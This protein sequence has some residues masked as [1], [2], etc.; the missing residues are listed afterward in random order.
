MHFA[1]RPLAAAGLSV[2]AACGSITDPTSSSRFP[3]DASFAKG[4]GKP[5][6]SPRPPILFVHGWNSNGSIWNTMIGRFQR[7]GWTSAQLHTFSYNSALSNTTTAAILDQKVDSIRTATGAAKVAI[8]THSMGSLSARYY[9]LNLGGD[10]LVSALVS[11]G[12][13][14]HGTSTAAACALFFGQP[15]CVEMMPNSTFLAALNAIDETPGSLPD[16]T[17]YAGVRAWVSQPAP[18]QLIASARW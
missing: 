17:V 2:L 9:V 7:D 1:I 5:P 8:V 14:N 11:L 12:G 15:S 16:A 6:K 18:S 13:P 10:G 4:G 3:S